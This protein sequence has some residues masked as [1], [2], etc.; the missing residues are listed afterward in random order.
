MSPQA[1]FQPGGFSGGVSQSFARASHP[2]PSTGGGAP[3]LLRRCCRLSVLSSRGVPRRVPEIVRPGRLLPEKLPIPIGI[4]A[5]RVQVNTR[6]VYRWI[7][8]VVGV[9]PAGR[10]Q[11]RFIAH[12]LGCFVIRAGRVAADSEGANNPVVFIKRHSPSDRNQS[13]FNSRRAAAGTLIGGHKIARDERVRCRD[14]PERMPGLY[15]RVPPRR[16]KRRVIQTECIRGVCFGFGDGKDSGP[17]L[18]GIR[19][20]SRNRASLSLPVYYDGPFTPAV[21]KA[22][23]IAAIRGCL[24]QKRFEFTDAGKIRAARGG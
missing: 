10:V 5:I 24:G 6:L 20:R 19:R 18:R 23:F 15:Q 12:S 7:G 16:G 14:S 17:N 13:S 1:A 4:R 2:W 22:P 8:D 3:S 11:A 21:K 9:H